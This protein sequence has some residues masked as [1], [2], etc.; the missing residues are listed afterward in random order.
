MRPLTE[1]RHGKPHGFPRTKVQH[2]EHVLASM[3]L[4]TT[5]CTTAGT[6]AEAD[7]LRVDTGRQGKRPRSRADGGSIASHPIA[8]GRVLVSFA[9][10]GRGLSG[11][12]FCAL[13]H[14]HAHLQVDAV[15]E[16]T[17]PFRLPTGSPLAAFLDRSGPANG[18]TGFCGHAATRYNRWPLASLLTPQP[19]L[20]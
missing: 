7:A 18:P 14:L 12:F 4:R 6:D 10:L 3:F 19:R 8:P 20:I 9:P 17:V 13:M 5:K 15:V 1:E 11:G 2:G 16:S